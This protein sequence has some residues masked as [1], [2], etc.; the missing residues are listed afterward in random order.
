MPKDIITPG[1]MGF[2]KP[3]NPNV[4]IKKDMQIS[5]F[6]LTPFNGYQVIAKRP[7]NGNKEN[8][9]LRIE[10]D[11]NEEI[12]KCSGSKNS[13]INALIRYALDDLK[14]K[15]VTLNYL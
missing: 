15:Q 5:S 9:A 1:F 8:F 6:N 4:I 3:K 7:Y 14:K 2:N 12:E 13:V 10:A 11:I